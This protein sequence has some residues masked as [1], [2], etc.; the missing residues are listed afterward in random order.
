M[1]STILLSYYSLNYFNSTC[2]T[3]NTGGTKMAIDQW[4][5]LDSTSGGLVLGAIVITFVLLEIRARRLN[6]SRLPVFNDRKWWEIGYGKATKRYIS[7]P[8]GLIKS[9]LEKVCKALFMQ[10][11]L[12]YS[13]HVYG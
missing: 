12:I 7:D 10:S 6:P 9:G 4:F 2:A 13:V 8:E 5:H 1:S 3:V 11:R